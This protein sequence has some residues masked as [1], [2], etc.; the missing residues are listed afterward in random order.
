[1]KNDLDQR[2]DIRG[3]IQRLIWS[4]FGIRR[5][6]AALR[7]YVQACQTAFNTKCTYIGMR[8]LIQENIAYRVWPL[9]N[10]WD[11]PKEERQ[12]VMSCLEPTRGLKTNL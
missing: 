12:Q 11:M 9:A 7:N 5:P 8:D 2:E 4:R 3:I 10:G 1:V 6:S